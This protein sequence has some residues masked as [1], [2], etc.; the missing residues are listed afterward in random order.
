VP[1][2]IPDIGSLRPTRN[3]LQQRPAD[4]R[5]WKAAG[6]F[7]EIFLAQFVKAMRGTPEDDG[8]LEPA[9]GRETYDA[10][11]SEAIARQM[12]ERDSLGLRDSI[13]RSI[14]GAYETL[15]PLPCV[16]PNEPGTGGATEVGDDR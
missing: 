2:A 15:K 3:E 8:L 9:A 6:E 12:A 1:D 4:R 5:L 16:R 7:E 13:Y 11:F 14:G 10:M